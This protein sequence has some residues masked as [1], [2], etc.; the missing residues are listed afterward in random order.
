MKR[1]SRE[2]SNISPI[3]RKLDF[4]NL[5]DSDETIIDLTELEEHLD[6]ISDTEEESDYEDLE[7]Y[8]TLMK[9][10]ETMR[11]DA[12]KEFFE[13]MNFALTHFSKRLEAIHKVTQPNYKH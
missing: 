3:V 5:S 10:R 1:K 9:M 2:V 13:E 6:E 8:V 11:V 12:F 7:E 4:N